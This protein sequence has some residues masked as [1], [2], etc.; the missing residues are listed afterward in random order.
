MPL[1]SLGMISNSWTGCLRAVVAASFGLLMLNSSHGQE[2][3]QLFDGRSLEGWKAAEKPESF[4][5][6][7]GAI[8]CQGARA[9]LFYEGDG[10]PFRNFEFECEAMTFSGANSGVY[11]HTVFQ[12]KGFPATGYEIQVLNEPA[13]HNGYRENKLT[14]SL[15]G[16]RNIYKSLV[17]DGQWFKL[18]IRVEGKRVR[19]WLNGTLLVDWVEPADMKAVTRKALGEGTFALQ[20]HDPT[21]KVS[22]RNLRVKRLPDAGAE[23]LPAGPAFTDYEKELQRLGAANFPVLNYHVHLKGGLTV[24]EA[25]ASSRSTG[26]FYGVAVNCGL[27]FS[28]TNDAGIK[29]YLRQMQGQPAFVAMQAE[30]REWVNMFSREATRQ[31]D[32][33]FTDAMTIVDDTGRRMRLWI[34]N[35]VPPITDPEAFMSML[36][37]RT[38]KILSQE[39]INVYVNPTFLPAQIASDYDRLWTAERMKRVVD[40]A[41]ARGIAIEIN[42]RLK[43]PNLAFLKLAKAAGCKFT[44]GT[45]NGDREIGKLDFSLQ[46]IKELGLGWKDFWVPAPRWMAKRNP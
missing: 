7:D 21:S 3:A 34:T 38:V 20:A 25:L 33:V 17:P 31:F 9:H 43:L 23:M 12:S 11:V 27:N 2:W 16:V 8:V 45:N 24:E 5:V 32:Y 13:E 44:M 10:K 19:T 35:E 40:A 28:V 14:G 41:A 30:G 39:P 6:E 1:S 37:D 46:M 42:N 15:Y 36:V 22:Y 18:A 29:D 26:I 4:R